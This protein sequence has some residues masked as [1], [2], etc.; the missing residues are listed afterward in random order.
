MPWLAGEGAGGFST[1]PW[2]WPGYE[3]TWPTNG[4]G[5]I[6]GVF[7]TIPA[8][9]IPFLNTII[10]VSSGGTITLA[11]WAL[12]KNERGKLC[13]RFYEGRQREAIGMR[14]SRPKARPVIFTPGGA[15]RRLYSLRST[16]WIMRVAISKSI[17]VSA[18]I[19]SLERRSST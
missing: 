11:H 7:E 9:G 14:R 10:L 18:R 12:K 2:L 3:G 15:C 19:S 13:W 4:P 8:F 5:D 6:G 16:I 1:G 17:S